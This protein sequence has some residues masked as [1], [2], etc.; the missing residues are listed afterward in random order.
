MPIG[1][2]KIGKMGVS[3]DIDI[4]FRNDHLVDHI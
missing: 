2:I 1:L 4:D 3:N